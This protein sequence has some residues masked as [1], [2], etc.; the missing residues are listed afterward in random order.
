MKKFNKDEFIKICKSS[1]SMAEAAS[2]IGV[3]F[4]TFKRH[5]IKFGCYEINQSGK[6]T[7]KNRKPNID[8]LEILDGKHPSFQTFKLKNRLLK[9][10]IIKNICGECGISEWNG[11]QINIE[12]DHVDGNRTNHRLNNLKMLCPNCHSQ[13]STFRARNI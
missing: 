2:I 13:T 5:A 6:G 12:L 4:N 3:H 8:L 7:T 1:K 11:K 9:A 10:C